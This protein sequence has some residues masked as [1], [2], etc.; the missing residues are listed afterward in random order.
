M[1]AHIKKS[2]G[3]AGENV[4]WIGALPEDPG[5]VPSTHMVAHNFCNFNSRASDTLAQ[6]IPAGKTPVNIKI[7][8]IKNTQIL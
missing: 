2:Q 7:T 4:Q 1:L 6:I 5:L 3:G 8:Y